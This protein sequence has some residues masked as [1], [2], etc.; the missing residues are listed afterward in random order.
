MLQLVLP[1]PWCCILSCPTLGVASCPV[2]PLVLQLVLSDPWCCNTSCPTLGLPDP[3]CCNSSYP[4]LGVATRLTRPL[5][6]Q[7]VLPDPWCCSSSCLTLGV[8]KS[9]RLC[10]SWNV[11]SGSFVCTWQCVDVKW[12]ACFV[13]LC[14]LLD[15][16]ILDQ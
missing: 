15:F 10:A 6:L 3:W 2:R 12:C 7:L 9:T 11:A 16:V 14:L 8:A 5:V 1:D 13:T 4:T